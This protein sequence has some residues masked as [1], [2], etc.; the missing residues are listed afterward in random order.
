MKSGIFVGFVFGL[1]TFVIGFG[2]SLVAHHLF[3]H[4]TMS[5]V[6]GTAIGSAIIP[7]IFGFFMGLQ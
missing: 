1:V 4:F 5:W 6:I 7:S 3:P 2:L